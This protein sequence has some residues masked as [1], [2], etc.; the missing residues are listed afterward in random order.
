MYDS[1]IARLRGAHIPA[2]Q[3]RGVRA[4]RGGLPARDSCAPQFAATNQR[5]SI[6]EA[7]S[8]DSPQRSCIFRSTEDPGGFSFGM[9]I[10]RRLA[11]RRSIVAASAIGGGSPAVEDHDCIRIGWLEFVADLRQTKA[12]VV[13][14][15]KKMHR[16]T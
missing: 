16:P 14:D 5:E 1:G 9:Q 13:V 11:N 3:W 12:V 8:V 4:Y 2:E 15:P 6:N 10:R 7:G